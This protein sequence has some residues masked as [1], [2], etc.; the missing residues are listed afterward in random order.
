MQVLDYAIYFHFS[1]TTA[2]RPLV[3]RNVRLL[4]KNFF[5][6]LFSETYL[7]F[8]I[9]LFLSCFKQERKFYWTER[10]ITIAFWNYFQ[11]ST[12]T[13]LYSYHKLKCFSC[14][15]LKQDTKKKK[16]NE[17]WCEE[18]SGV[19]N[20]YCIVFY[21]YLR[22]SNYLCDETFSFLNVSMQKKKEILCLLCERV[23]DKKKKFL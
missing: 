22:Y 8:R 7:I 19:L 20:S 16:V 2:T 1:P 13:L 11:L 23:V 17:K 9:I 15:L 5:F 4:Y 14:L 21:Y 3:R 12:W 6:V 10:R 18:A